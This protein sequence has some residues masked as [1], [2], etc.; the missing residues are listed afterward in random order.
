MIITHFNHHDHNFQTSSSSAL[1][2]PLSGYYRYF[3]EKKDRG[4]PLYLKCVVYL[5]NFVWE[6]LTQPPLLYGHFSFGPC[7]TVEI[8]V[9]IT[10]LLA[11]APCLYHCIDAFQYKKIQTRTKTNEWNDLVSMLIRSNLTNSSDLAWRRKEKKKKW[12]DGL[13]FAS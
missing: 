13:A 2:A 1:F 11:S 9:M 4:K 10:F 5:G 7:F 6:I 12:V 3:A 8:T